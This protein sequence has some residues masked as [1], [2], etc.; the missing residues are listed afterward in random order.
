MQ[1]YKEGYKAGEEGAWFGIMSNLF[2]FVVKIFAGIFGRSQAMVADAVHTGSDALTS[3]GVLIGFR[4]ARKPADEHH[5][6]GHGKTESF[7]ASIIAMVLMALGV[8]I[9]FHSGRTIL[10]GDFGIPGNVAL[11]VALIS[12]VVKEFTY[13]RVIKMGNEIGSASLK[14]DAYHHRSDVLSSVAAFIGILGARIGYPIMD[15]LASIVVAG[16]IVKM[17]ADTFHLAYDELLDAAPPDDFY[18]KIRGLVESV[19]GVAQIKDICVRKAGI[20]HFLEITIGVKGDMSVIESHMI[21]VKIKNVLCGELPS[22]KDV[23]VHV[24]PIGSKD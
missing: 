24:E 17:G 8:I 11:I 15:P 5:P 3:I 10:S 1:T 13:R 21:T 4:I 22:V 20:E 7:V 23:V 12:I 6:L 16:F 18:A 2:L 9:I 19:D 14:A